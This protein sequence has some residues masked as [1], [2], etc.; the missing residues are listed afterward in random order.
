MFRRL[1]FL[2]LLLA[3]PLEEVAF[4]S[5]YTGPRSA[6][7]RCKVVATVEEAHSTENLEWRP[8]QGD[9]LVEA[10]R[11]DIVAFDDNGWNDNRKMVPKTIYLKVPASSAGTGHKLLVHLEFGPKY[12]E[13][14][15]ITGSTIKSRAILP[16]PEKARITKEEA[17]RAASESGFS[18][19]W[20]RGA[21]IGGNWHIS[22]SSKSANAPMYFVV[23]GQDGSVVF[24]NTNTDV[25]KVPEEFKT[26]KPTEE[27]HNRGDEWER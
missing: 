5:K 9:T 12:A 27:W 16:H 6:D 2:I 24:R 15:S 4:T 25:E 18:A 13:K 23:D 3:F 7:V 1:G 22:G 19:T 8:E 14:L 10:K 26:E 21:L 17:Y 20:T 11:L